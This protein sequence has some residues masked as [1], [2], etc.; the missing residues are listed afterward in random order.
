[1]LHTFIKAVV[2]FMILIYAGMANA[3]LIKVYL[4]GDSSLFTTCLTVLGL[5]LMN[6]STGWFIV[7]IIKTP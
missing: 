3:G 2:V 5:A 1:M 4:S 6:I 7:K